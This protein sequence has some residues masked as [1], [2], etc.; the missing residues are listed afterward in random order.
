MRAKS[1]VIF[2]FPRP[3]AKVQKFIPVTNHLSSIFD[4]PFSKAWGGV[5]GISKA[6]ATVLGIS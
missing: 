3:S 6:R 1:L 5:E 4:F 2:W